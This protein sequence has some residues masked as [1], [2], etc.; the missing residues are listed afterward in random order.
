MRILNR[1]A[2]TLTAKQPFIDW[3]NNAEDDDFS[4]TLEQL[5]EDTHVYL[6]PESG[7][8]IP[9]TV[10]TVVKPHFKAIFEEELSGW[11]TPEAMWPK[12]R[13]FKTF[14]EWFDVHLHSVVLDTVS[15]GFIE[16]DD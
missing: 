11:F 9:F 8:K 4:I 7:D 3:I 12:R 15:R 6:I 10:E 16:F 14:L 1:T 5:Q 13:G 2:I